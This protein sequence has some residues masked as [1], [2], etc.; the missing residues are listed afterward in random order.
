MLK[1]CYSKKSEPSARLIA[2]AGGFEAVRSSHGDINWGRN[3][4][5]T[6]LNADTSRVTNKRVMRQLFAEARIPMPELI[7]NPRRAVRA[8]TSQPGG[9]GDGRVIVGRPDYH[10]KGRGFWLCKSL[11]D[12]E[13]ALDGT[14]L[15]KPATHFMEFIQAP[16]EL[17]AHVFMGKSIRISLK[18]I[19]GREGNHNIYTTAKP[20]KH[21]RDLVREPAKRAVEAVGLDFGAVD[22]LA[23]DTE[24][25]VLEVNSAPGVGGT[26]PELYARVFKDW[27]END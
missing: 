22:I 14:R 17:R 18:D 21:L 12:V 11:R 3:D 10:S 24:C 5:N 23:T 9:C 20:P 25:W 6:R 26:M 27:K 16:Y 13:R 15:K 19:S 1:I 2:E 4:A 8:G 7:D